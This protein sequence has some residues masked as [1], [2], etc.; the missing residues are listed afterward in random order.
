MLKDEI[1]K[2]LILRQNLKQKIKI[3][4]IRIKINPPLIFYLTNMNFKKRRE[5]RGDKE[6]NNVNAYK[7]LD[8]TCIIP[9]KSLWCDALEDKMEDCFW[10]T[11]KLAHTHL[12][13]MGL[14]H[15]MVCI[16]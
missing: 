11:K 4:I 15:M 5:N 1:K 3:K 10:P 14:L 9:M 7:L 2:K 16:V 8:T 12:N 13:A 6:K